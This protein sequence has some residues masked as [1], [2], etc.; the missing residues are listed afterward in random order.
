MSNNSSPVLEKKLTLDNNG[1]ESQTQPN[2]INE[3]DPC[4]KTSARKDRR[5]FYERTEEKLR[6][7]SG[8]TRRGLIIAGVVLF[9]LFILFIIVIVLGICWPRTP[10]ERQFPICEDAACLRAVAQVCTFYLLLFCN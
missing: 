7:K 4:L 8:L 2:N 10:H 1:I 9:I 6:E 3:N 5:K